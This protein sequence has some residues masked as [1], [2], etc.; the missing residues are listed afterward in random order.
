MHLH[1][2]QNL[3]SICVVPCGIGFCGSFL[4]FTSNSPWTC[5][6]YL[7]SQLGIPWQSAMLAFL[8]G[9]TWEHAASYHAFHVQEAWTEIECLID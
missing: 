2:S 6:V 7:Q 9:K 1:V 5:S 8:H 3:T 4:T